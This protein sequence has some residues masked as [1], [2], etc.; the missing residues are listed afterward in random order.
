[1]S[2]Y[3]DLILEHY[4]HP[5]NVGKLSHPTGQATLHNPVC[6]DSLQVDI[7]EKNGIVVDIM[8]QGTGCAIS[9]AAASILT[10]YVKG[11]TVEEIH[12]MDKKIVLQLLGIELSPVRL[13]CALLS[14]EAIQKALK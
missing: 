4:R 3:Q 11:K 6:G 10:E 8:F 2:I 12:T 14:L 1:M 5:Q 7:R 13:K 9:Q